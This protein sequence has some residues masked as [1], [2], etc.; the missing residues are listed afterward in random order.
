MRRLTRLRPR[1]CTATRA[2]RRTAVAALSA[3]VALVLLVAGCSWDGTLP[4]PDAT[5][6]PQRAAAELATGLARRD[7]TTVE[8]AGA[9]GS[10]VDSA[11]QAL[12]D[13]MGGLNRWSR[14][15]GSTSRAIPRPSSWT[16]SGRSP[17][18]RLRGRT[19]HGHVAAG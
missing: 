9:T 7:L 19:E 14:S 17:A 12:V 2:G 3:W 15:P 10:A 8:F 6:D 11:F 1:W 13:G 5:D 4:T 16:T 18:Y